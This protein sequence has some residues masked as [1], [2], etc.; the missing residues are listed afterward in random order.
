MFTLQVGTGMLIRGTVNWEGSSEK[1]VK[2]RRAREKEEQ[3]TVI[4]AV[5]RKV[6]VKITSEESEEDWIETEPAVAIVTE[7]GMAKRSSMIWMKKLL[8]EL[9]SQAV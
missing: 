6:P 5:K 2:Q 8:S 7:S 3:L 1:E 9:G 4:R